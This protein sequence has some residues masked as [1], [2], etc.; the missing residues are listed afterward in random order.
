[1]K[2]LGELDVAERRRPQDGAFQAHVG[3]RIFNL[4][5]STSSTP[6]GESLV[7]RMLEPYVKPQEM[8]SLGMSGR[9]TDTLIDL[10]NR[11]NGLL[12]IVGPTGSGK[13]TTIYSL[14]NNIDCKKRSLISVEDPIEYRIP[15]ANQQQVNDKAGI[16]FAS[17]L[18]TSV[19]QDPDILFLGEIR[20]D[21]SARVA[22][23]FASTGHLTL[24]SLHTSN[25]TT[26]IFRLE[27]LGVGRGEMGDAVLGIVAQRLLKKLCPHCKKI[28]PI[29]QEESEILSQ[30][31]DDIPAE[32]AHPVGCPK[33]YNNG[34]M[35]REGVYEIINFDAEVSEMIRED[36]SISEI[37]A[38]VFQR[39]DYLLSGHAILKIRNH[40]TS[41]EE[42]YKKVLIE[43]TDFKEASRAKTI[44]VPA[45]EVPSPDQESQIL[46]VEDDE[47]TR[48]IIVRFLENEG[49]N[50]K[51]AEDGIEAL[52]YLGKEPF[53]LILSDVNMPNLDGFKLLEMISQKGIKTNVV[54]LSGRESTEDE[55]KGFR[56][57]A[58]DYIRKPVKKDVLLLSPFSGRIFKKSRLTT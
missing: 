51:M 29:S 15:L 52:L 55:E 3:E 25:A 17:L 53:D 50:V 30:F 33:C 8:S 58:S 7:I 4:R 54:F 46:V 16:T 6:N 47:S 36:A 20:D 26:A 44:S 24:S 40:I 39:G 45:V 32:V 43:D 41:L 2:A 21:Y 1:M 23:D 14:L 38:F 48:N 42:A 31:T 37:R 27:R 9:Q 56:L 18:K 57:G 12:L 34:Y 5:L 13:T 49:Y 22:L 10:S 28:D 19:R 35:G 11:T